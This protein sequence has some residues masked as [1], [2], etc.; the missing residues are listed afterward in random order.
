M[1]LLLNMY[2]HNR[3]EPIFTVR[4]SVY[5][6]TESW[7]PV[8]FYLSASSN[9]LWFDALLFSLYTTY[10]LNWTWQIVNVKLDIQLYVEC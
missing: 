3:H 1:M 8:L 9:Q 10:Y 7:S 6:T 5:S 4:A 2:F